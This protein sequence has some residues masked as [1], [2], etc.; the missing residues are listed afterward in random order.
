M[1]GTRR[2]PPPKPVVADDA[3]GYTLIELLVTLAIAGLLAAMI[4]AGLAT[5]GRALARLESD[6][7][8]MEAVVFAQQGLRY[9]LEGLR[10]IIRLDSSV[11]TVDAQGDEASFTFIAPPLDR[12]EPDALWRYR[13]VVTASGELVL[14]HANS[15]DRRFDVN[16]PGISGWQPTKLLTN[17]GSLRINYFG[18][19]ALS[20]ERRWQ[21][22]WSRRAQPP[23]LIRISLKFRKGDKRAWPDLIVRPRATIN[24]ACKIDALTGRCDFET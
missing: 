15:L 2:S 19:D 21:T 5:S 8:N 3:A 10:A 13:I 17:V 16:A 6:T 18:R 4:L 23:D 12:A 14:F 9:R 7:I 11:P 24:A 20:P 1:K 22:R